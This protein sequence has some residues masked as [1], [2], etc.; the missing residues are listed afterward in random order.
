MCGRAPGNCQ[1]ALATRPTA[2]HAH[3]WPDDPRAGMPGTRG[4]PPNRAS[5]T[6]A[7]RVAGSSTKKKPA[8]ATPAAS[9]PI[10]R[11]VPPRASRVEVQFNS[12]TF[13]GA[14]GSRAKAASPFPAPCMCLDPHPPAPCMCPRKRIFWRIART[15]DTQNLTPHDTSIDT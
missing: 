14:R 3:G 5:S 10:G 8:A 2:S 11:A 12:G 15:P 1:S 6:R 7:A 9:L 4:H 13:V